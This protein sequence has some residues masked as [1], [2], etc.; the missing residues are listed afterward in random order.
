M[1]DPNSAG[2]HGDRIRALFKGSA[3]NATVVA[4]FI[5]LNA[6]RS[7]LDVIRSDTH[8]RCVT[9]WLPREI[10]AGVSDPEILELLE[11][12]GNFSLTL[13]DW[14]HAKLYISDDRCLA[15]SA[16]VTLAGLGD[17]DGNKNIE[18]LVETTVDNPGIAATLREIA[19]VE[20][21]ATKEI[22]ETA[23]HLANS[24]SISTTMTAD[25]EAPWFPGSR[26]PERAYRFYTEPPSGY[27]RASDRI[28]LAD[29][30]GSNIQPGLEKD[31]FQT[32]IRSL[33]AA[34]PIAKPI[35]ESAEDTTITRA[36]AHAYLENIAGDK[37]SSDDLWLAF[38]N[39]MAHF[40]PDRIMKQEISEIA[41]RGARLL[42][43]R[44]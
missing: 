15:G 37:F 16:N 4:P 40:Y 9:R 22:A 8:L 19:Q 35:L 12:R 30:A 31:E 25:L 24:L 36:D 26:R 42:V 32:A 14:L 20:R 27:V 17:G 34:I 1:A 13:V 2:T 18:V 7:L 41:L 5:K 6:L 21:P 28:L 3:T 10:A 23:R 29:L 43:P 38:V 33:L 39:W 11:E 44:L